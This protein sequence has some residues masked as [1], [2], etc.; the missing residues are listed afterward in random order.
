MEGTVKV[1][2]SQ[3]RGLETL[4]RWKGGSTDCDFTELEHICGV[5]QS[6]SDSRE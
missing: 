3:R 2:V 6:A 4:L 1:K 5:S